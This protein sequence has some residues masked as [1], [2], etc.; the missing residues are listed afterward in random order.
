MSVWMSV[1]G[2]K[3]LLFIAMDM[4]AMSLFIKVTYAVIMYVLPLLILLAF[5]GKE[6]REARHFRPTI[7]AG[8]KLAIPKRKLKYFKSQ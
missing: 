1:D 6:Q 5:I 8:P 4:D 3:T 2:M 7:M